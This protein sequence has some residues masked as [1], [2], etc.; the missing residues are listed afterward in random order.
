MS[1]QTPQP[2]ATLYCPTCEHMFAAGEVCPTDGSRL[3]SL[4]AQVDPFV[5]RDLDGRYV[6][7]DKLG[8]GG[9]G[10]VYRG[11]QTSVGRD[12]AIK[13]V[14]PA[15]IGSPEIIKRFLRE[16]K[17]ASKLNHPNA[18]AVLD[19]GQTRDGVFYLVMELI[20][21]RTLG[22]IIVAEERLAPE[23]VVAIGAQILNALE[24][25][26]AVPIVHRDLKPP[27]IMI[28]TDDVV[29]VLDFGIAK[30]ISPDTIAST[31]TNAGA[32]LGTPHFMPPEIANGGAFDGRADLY[33][34]GCILYMMVEG[35]MP[36]DGDTLPE[37]LYQHTNMPVP[38]L[39]LAPRGL[40]RV[41]EKL[42]AKE[43]GERY[44]T[45]ASAR[46][47]L[48]HALAT[49]GV[50]LAATEIGAP[51]VA[52]VGKRRVAWPLIAAGVAI[53]VGAGVAI[54]IG[55]GGA[56][57]PVAPVEQAP[58]A[59]TAPTPAAPT[60]AAITPPE[61]PPTLAGSGDST[62]Q[63]IAPVL[64]KPA[65]SGKPAPHAVRPST[66]APKPVSKPAH[67]PSTNPPPPF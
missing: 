6:V 2:D 3:V 9:M 22:E 47:A 14:N 60:P 48:E 37:L 46:A 23:R 5:G 20:R 45:A 64:A 58:V 41:I 65:S 25:A 16:A 38:P 39:Q 42:L 66:H 10:A 40:A 26:H 1:M 57:V 63:A 19:F 51:P 67:A 7:G 49:T 21:G 4:V 12:V 53:A 11:T 62:D 50:E 13:V 34:L 17:L 36:F 8:Q 54:A 24:G 52:S 44:A 32:L 59:P 55:S 56:A 33:S 27:N 30:S 35:R 28:G 43:P 18:V 29:K 61:A 31:M 15:Q